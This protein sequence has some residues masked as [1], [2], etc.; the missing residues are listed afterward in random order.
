MFRLQNINPNGELEGNPF[1]MHRDN[2]T[3]V[4]GDEQSLGI[5]GSTGGEWSSDSPKGISSVPGLKLP[6]TPAMAKSWMIHDP[7][8]I[9]SM[10]MKNPCMNQTPRLTIHVVVLLLPE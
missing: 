5:S 2:M 1:L 7:W 4:P 3:R 10:A 6:K 8:F 9:S